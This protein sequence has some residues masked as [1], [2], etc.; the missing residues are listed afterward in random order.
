MGIKI[1]TANPTPEP[2]DHFQ[3]GLQYK[4]DEI[5]PI[6][7]QRA[8]Q[9]LNHAT[10]AFEVVD[11]KIKR[12]E[13]RPEDLP[14]GAVEAT[15]APEKIDLGLCPIPDVGPANSIENLRN[16]PIMERLLAHLAVIIPL[17]REIETEEKWLEKDRMRILESHMNEEIGSNN[18]SGVI[19]L[20]GNIG[21]GAIGLFAGQG[22]AQ[23]A[24]TL[25]GAL[26]TFNRSNM[27]YDQKESQL[28]Q[29]E[30]DNI[31]RERQQVEGLRQRILEEMHRF[32]S[33]FVLRG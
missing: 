28:S 8:L 15:D 31:K 7:L 18:L 9:E 19:S 29:S 26:D 23:I 27:I 6:L 25:V 33:A 3:N 5:D 4:E 16:L 17:L 21:A 2:F 20:F 22:G 13:I 32:D 11:G 24:S 10:D 1:S 12:K 14:S 30:L